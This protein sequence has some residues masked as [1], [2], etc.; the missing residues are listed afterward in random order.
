MKKLVV[1]KQARNEACDALKEIADAIGSTL[2]PQGQPFVFERLGADQRVKPTASKDGIT[3]LNSL[4]FDVPIKNAVHF[5]AQQAASHSVMASGDGTTS[6][7]VLAAAV[8]DQIRK[9]DDKAPQA[10]ARMIRSEARKCVEAIRAEADRSEECVKKVAL[11]SANGDAELVK[12]A[13]NAV[14]K[15][16][17]FGSVMI[18]KSPASKARYK[19]SRQDGYVA[20]RGY[21]Y[22]NTF[23]YS[24]DAAA[25]ENAP[26]EWSEPNIL[27]FNGNIF[28]PEQ[29]NAILKGF[30]EVTMVQG[31]GARLVVFC[32]EIAEELLNQLI[33]F[34]RK[35]AEHDIAIFVAKPRLTA[36]INS[37]LQVIRD[38]AA[39]TNSNI[40][41]GGNYKTISGKDFG[42]AKSV[43]MTPTQTI[44]QGRAKNHWVDKRVLQNQ[45]IIAAAE[46]PFDKELTTIRNAELAEGLVRVEVGGGLLPDL[47]ERADRMD[48]AIKAAQACMRDG[49]LPGCGA[50]YIRSAELAKAHPAIQAAFRVVHDQI[51]TNFG[52]ESKKRF[53]KG[54]T[55]F[56]G[57]D[58]TK[59]GDFLDLE[60]VDACETVCSVIENGVQLGCLTA[61]LGGYSLYDGLADIQKAQLFK[62]LA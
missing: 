15:S 29:I 35:N 48:D 3:A 13:L 61:T 23:A 54:Q 32:Y 19:V 6:T 22:N 36:E 52:A 28:V 60:V 44:L 49:A 24:A 46:S 12:V 59:A 8:A 26:F 14:Q 30:N 37:G 31:K 51:M 62:S 4:Q 50:S 38:I 34:N 9:A 56:V 1:G 39:Y 45:N 16:S 2:G 53:D 42:T 43:K 40:V 25:S 33:V 20:A 21:N 17:A 18:D 58:T 10:F 47:Q 27:V 55:V 7:V 5:F 57:E 41:D 11:T